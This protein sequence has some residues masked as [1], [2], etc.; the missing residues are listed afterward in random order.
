MSSFTPH[1]RTRGR[2]G[3]ERRQGGRPG[4]ATLLKSGIHVLIPAMIAGLSFIIES[5]DRPNTPLAFTELIA[6]ERKRINEGQLKRNDKFP[7]QEER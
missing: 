5:Y 7:I 6:K 4:R 2:R 3:R 1:S